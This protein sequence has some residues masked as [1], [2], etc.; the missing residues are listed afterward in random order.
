MLRLLLFQILLDIQ[1]GVIRRYDELQVAKIILTSFDKISISLVF[2][3][4][5]YSKKH[6]K[7]T[8]DDLNI[9]ALKFHWLKSYCC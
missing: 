2:T 9:R 5:S 8:L 6:G 7:S 3:T 1:N 4:Q